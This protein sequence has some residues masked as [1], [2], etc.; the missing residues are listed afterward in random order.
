MWLIYTSLLTLA[1]VAHVVLCA[2][3]SYVAP[4]PSRIIVKDPEDDVPETATL[5]QAP[6]AASTSSDPVPISDNL[7][8]SDD[9]W[10]PLDVLES[11]V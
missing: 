3:V 4:P 6:V 1:L 8:M 9:G 7:S 5:L 10:E 11:Q 2:V